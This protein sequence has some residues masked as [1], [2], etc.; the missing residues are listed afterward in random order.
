MAHILG[1]VYERSE[2]IVGKGECAVHQHLLLF[3]QC[4]KWLLLQSD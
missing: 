1:F 2:N 3:P 4:F